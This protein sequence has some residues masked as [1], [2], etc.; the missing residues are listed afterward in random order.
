MKTKNNETAP[1]DTDTNSALS[2]YKK[3]AA[4]SKGITNITKDAHNSFHKYD[5]VSANKLFEAIKPLML[6]Q[7]LIISATCESSAEVGTMTSIMMRYRIIDI[8]TGSFIDYVIPG[9]G[10][11]KGDK[12]VYKAMTGALKYLLIQAFQVS[13]EDDPEAEG[14]KPVPRKTA[15]RVE[16]PP[17]KTRIIDTSYAQKEEIVSEEDAKTNP[18]TWQIECEDNARVGEYLFHIDGKKLAEGSIK[19]PEKFTAND[20]KKIRAAL[21]APEKQMQALEDYASMQKIYG[22]NAQIQPSLVDDKIPY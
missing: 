12:G 17:A 16:P 4:T 20:L 14:E 18:W 7:G 3:L 22:P 15:A 9:Q 6:E 8:D 1:V 2:V 5:Y 21:K 11:D 10:Q 19:A 13:T